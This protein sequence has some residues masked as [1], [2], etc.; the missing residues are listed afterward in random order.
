MKV[1]GTPPSAFSTGQGAA[2]PA[3]GGFALDQAAGSG[4]AVPASPASAMSAVGS[5]EA[6]LALQETPSPLER[7][8]KAI[9]RGGRILDAL[10]TLRLS[11]FDPETPDASALKM[12]QAAVR[13]AR[14]QA[15]EPGLDGVLEEI[16]V[17]A[18]VEL[19]KREVRTAA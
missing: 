12:L 6:L 2:R 19:A 7:R 13:E 5:L 18:A 1:N 17:R 4:A 8:R 3:A 9:R 14:S 15:D 11:V 10:E 16:E